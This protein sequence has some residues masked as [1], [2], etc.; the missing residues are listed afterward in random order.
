MTF[1]LVL[2]STGLSNKSIAAHFLRYFLNRFN[3]FIYTVQ[4][5]LNSILD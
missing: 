5:N 1:I 3:L 2:F 4:D